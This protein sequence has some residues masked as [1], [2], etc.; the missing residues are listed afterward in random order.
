MAVEDDKTNGAPSFIGKLGQMLQ[1]AAAGPFVAWSPSGDSVVV[2][3]SASFAQQVLPRFVSH[4]PSAG[5][6]CAHAE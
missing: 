6:L 2:I 3:D 5:P 4:Q 1:D